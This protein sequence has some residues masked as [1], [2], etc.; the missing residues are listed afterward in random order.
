MIPSSGALWCWILAVLGVTFFPTDAGTAS[1]PPAIAVF[2]AGT[3]F[4]FLADLPT[5]DA[6][7]GAGALRTADC[8]A[9]PARGAAAGAGG[10]SPTMITSK[11]VSTASAPVTDAVRQKPGPIRNA[12]R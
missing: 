1:V 7:P 9:L 3:E 4:V 12:I 10:C 8:S 5:V 6:A 11:Q 2:A